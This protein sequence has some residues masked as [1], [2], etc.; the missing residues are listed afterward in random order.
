MTFRP[1]CSNVQMLIGDSVVGVHR[2]PPR[3]E[4]DLEGMVR[5]GWSRTGP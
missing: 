3:H 1:A 5:A 2:V 4:E